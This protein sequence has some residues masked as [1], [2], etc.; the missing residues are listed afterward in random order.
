ML[1]FAIGATV[2]LGLAVTAPYWATTQ[3]ANTQ[4]SPTATHPVAPA[5]PA[6]TQGKTAG[7][8]DSDGLVGSAIDPKLWMDIQTQL[9]RASS[10]VVRFKSDPKMVALMQQARGIFIVPAFGHGTSPTTGAWGTAVLMANNKGQWSNA[11]F[12]T[13]GGG[14][15]GPHVIANGGALVLFIMND[16]AMSKFE[17]GSNW[18]LSA[19]P[20]P[21]AAANSRPGTTN[22]ATNPKSGA[23]VT[24][25]GN[26]TNSPPGT[27]IV[28][29]SAATPQDL[30][31]QGADII[32][33]SASG[34]PNSDTQVSISGI[35]ANT[36]L[37]GTVYGTPDMRNI[38]ANRS[39]YINQDVIN[40]R[41]AMSS[42]ANVKT[43]GP[44]LGPS[45][46]A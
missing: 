2:V 3:A 18:S 46:H 14:S 23:N 30:S 33:W 32:A 24:P 35:A 12:F 15:L 9:S 13:L 26:A 29:Y 21:T 17:S 44:Q 11:A 19:P 6:T 7:T 31:G 16:R 37:N 25:P 40:L 43:A 4:R 20:N 42:A 34:G 22:V 28:N 36:A 8:D 1:R 38:L 27:N 41:R 5:A 45:R 39:P 10:V